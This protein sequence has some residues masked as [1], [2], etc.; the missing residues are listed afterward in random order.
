M[1]YKISVTDLAKFLYN[2]GDLTNEFFS[3]KRTLEGQI[4]HSFLQEQYNSTS[5]KEVRISKSAVIGSDNLTVSGIMDGLIRDNGQIIIEEIKSTKLQLDEITIDYHRE[6]SAQLKFYGYMF[7]ANNDLRT[8]KLRLTYITIEDRETKSIYIEDDFDSLEDFFMDSIE[9]YLSWL[10]NLKDARNDKIKSIKEMVFP[11]DDMRAGQRDL[12]A[13]TYHTMSHDEILYAIAPTGI[14]KTMA[15]LFSSL[16]TLRQEND[17]LF[18]CTAKGMQKDIAIKSIRILENQGLKLKSIVLTAKSKMC[19]NDTQRCNPKYCKYAAGYFGRLTEAIKEIFLSTNVYD[20]ETITNIAKKHEICPFEFSLDLSYFCDLIVADYNYVFDPRAHLIRYFEDES[21]RP[22]VLIDEAHNLIDRS[23]EMYSSFVS[24]DTLKKLR[25]LLRNKEPKTTLSLGKAIKKIES[26]EDL[27]NDKMIFYSKTFDEDLINLLEKVIRKCDQV[28]SENKEFTGRE[29]AIEKYFEIYD[30]LDKSRLYGPNH[31]F[32]VSK[33]REGFRADIKCLDAS[34]FLLKT[35][36]ESI[37]GIVFFSATMFPLRYH[38]DL[39]TKNNGKYIVLNSPF[40]KKNLDLIVRSDVSTK[41]KRR[42]DSIDPIVGCIENLVKSKV[43]NYI[44]F[45]P[46]YAYM[47][48]VKDY[49]VD[50]NIELITQEQKM[51]D[52]KR[53]Q[54]LEKFNDNTKTKLGLFVLG[55]VFS[56]G[57]DLDGDKLSGVVVVGVGIPQVNVY[58]NILKEHFE[59]VYSDGFNY[60]YTYPGFNK[61]V[62][63]A[64]RVIRTANDRGIVILIDERFKYKHYQAL[65]PNSWSDRKFI[66]SEY[67]LEKEID[68]FIK[69]GKDEEIN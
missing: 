45:F 39:L 38:M 62:Q 19:I 37:H 57:I 8:V 25:G 56:E 44:V 52:E 30:F 58:N 26:Y 1:D 36:E 23:R 2:S 46:S 6:Y 50:L 60:A 9:K 61:I 34:D 4:A 24:T 12:M 28:F 17:K 33:E 40:P 42:L 11:F 41:Y 35:I 64:G 31:V 43:G 20:K 51:S 15:T 49:L 10:V 16:K 69:D 32:V 27:I 54:I 66:V 7:M 29:D 14:G 5:Q 55:G 65:M 13:A 67:G 47:N 59:S 21:Y 18:Y 48:M 3:N 63:A 22:K 53:R 68:L